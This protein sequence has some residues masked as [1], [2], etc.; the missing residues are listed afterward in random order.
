[1][2]RSATR[3]TRLLA[4]AAVPVMLVVAGCSSDS[5]SGS[6]KSSSSTSPSPSA[7]ASPTVAKAAYAKLPDACKSLSS[8]TVSDL[9]PK[10]KDKAGTEV[11][12]SDL[13]ARAGCSWNGLESKGTKGSQY[14]WLSV[15]YLR[16]DSDTVLGSGADRAGEQYTKAVADAKATDGA[17]NVKT[18]TTSGIGQEA[19]TVTYGQ[20]K[21]DADFVYAVV[22]TR[23]ENV[24][25]TVNHNG[26]GFEGAKSPSADDMTK[27]A[28]TA[29]KE[30]VASVATANK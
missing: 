14:R 2:H 24:V 27:G 29:A 21:T 15:S 3:L 9:V 10:A 8:K 25:T 28:Q 26:A 19:T 6:K 22:I 30:A 17:K 4:C 5:G 23:S 11:K 16:Y 13:A 12:S 1:M 20:R 7:P 18:V